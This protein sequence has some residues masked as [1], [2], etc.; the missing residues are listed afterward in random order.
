[1]RAAT[2]K[3][4]EVAMEVRLNQD[5]NGLCDLITGDQCGNVIFAASGDLWQSKLLPSVFSLWQ[6]QQDE[7]VDRD[8]CRRQLKVNE[9]K[10]TIFIMRNPA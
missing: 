3:K 1:M 8:V 2:L 6:Q 5:L 7:G 10:S 4:Q 9:N